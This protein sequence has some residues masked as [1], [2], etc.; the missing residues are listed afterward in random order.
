MIKLHNFLTTNKKINKT[1]L[2]VYIMSRHGD[3][4]LIEV[5]ANIK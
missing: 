4:E 5:I 3:K 2:S 1:L